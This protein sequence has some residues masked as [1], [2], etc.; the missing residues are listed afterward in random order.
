SR[1]TAFSHVRH[2]RRRLVVFRPLRLPVKLRTLAERLRRMPATA[3]AA[4]TETTRCHTL[5][6]AAEARRVFTMQIVG[7]SAV[8]LATRTCEALDPGAGDPRQPRDSPRRGSLGFS[9]R[10]DFAG[11]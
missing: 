3:R 5:Q 2:A 11:A 7:R 8:A 10:V 1:F 6:L 9:P 4:G